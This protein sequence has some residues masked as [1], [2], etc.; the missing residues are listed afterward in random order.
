MSAPELTALKSMP[1]SFP[2]LF[3]DWEFNPDPIAIHVG[4]GIYW[5]GIILAAACLAGLLLCMRQAKRYGLTEDHVLDLVLWAV[6]C[7]ILGSR[8]YYVIFYLDLY[9]DASGALD[10]SRVVAIWDGGIAIYGTVIAGALVVFFFT[11]RRK[12]PFGALSDLAVMG[13]LLGQIIGR[14]ANFINREA[15]GGPTEL[16]WR[17]RVWVSAYESVDVHP[18]FLYESLWNLAGLLLIL[19]VVSKGR[20]FDGEN[21]CFYFLWYGLGRAWIEGLRTDSLYLFDWTFFGSPIRVSQALS[22][23]MAAA[24]AAALFYQLRIRQRTPDGLLVNHLKAEAASAPGDNDGSSSGE[25]A[26]P[27]PEGPG[28]TEPASPEGGA[29]GNPD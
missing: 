15:F 26:S 4:H 24:A 18:T 1:I 22:L 17:M 23:A 11:R 7:C 21:T 19:L 25:S 12:I 14:W 20:R 2:G 8:I 10:W 5:Y 29:D 6:P 16:P 9:R 13:L 28:V 27:Q 3:G